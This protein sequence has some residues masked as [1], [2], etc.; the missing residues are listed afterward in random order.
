ME[1]METVV[2]MDHQFHPE[3]ELHPEEN[4]LKTDNETNELECLK[5]EMQVK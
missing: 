2:F 3:S 1:P 5:V 4:F